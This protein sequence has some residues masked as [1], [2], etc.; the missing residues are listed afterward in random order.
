MTEKSKEDFASSRAPQIDREYWGHNV[1]FEDQN[2]EMHMRYLR[3]RND[4]RK[5]KFEKKTGD[6]KTM[7]LSKIKLDA[8]DE[9]FQDLN[10][11]LNN[12]LTEI[13][14]ENNRDQGD[15]PLREEFKEALKKVQR[16]NK[17]VKS[18]VAKKSSEDKITFTFENLYNGKDQ[19]SPKKAVQACRLK[20]TEFGIQIPNITLHTRYLKLLKAKES[21]I[22]EFKAFEIALVF[23]DTLAF[24]IG[25]YFF[26]HYT[27][28]KLPIIQQLFCA[29]N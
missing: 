27:V 25:D 21:N 2:L 29:K 6:I 11:N 4:D 22:T 20:K 26:E 17:E 18:L 13:R 23:H 7:V 15:G 5:D 9:D 19:D 10:K 24:Y 14:L 8:K 12:A 1:Y 28:F 16:L 3:A